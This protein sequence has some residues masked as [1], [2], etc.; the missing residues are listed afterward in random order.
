MMHDAAVSLL[1]GFESDVAESWPH[2]FQI[3]ENSPDRHAALAMR[4]TTPNRKRDYV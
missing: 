3:T 2:I 4:T 1:T